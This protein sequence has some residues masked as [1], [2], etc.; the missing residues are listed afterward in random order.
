MKK[1]ES[2][3]IAKV[4]ATCCIACRL[5]GIDDSPAEA[6]HIGNGA[7]GKKAS[8]YEAIALCPIHHRLG[9]HGVAVHSGRKA[10]ESVF[11][12]EQYLLEI[13]LNLLNQ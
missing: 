10:F 8:N 13:T 2:D 3:Y 5:N 11:G 9:G 6:H 7:M 1:S 12:T 4:V